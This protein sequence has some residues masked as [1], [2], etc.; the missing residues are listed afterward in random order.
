MIG[1]MAMG[2]HG[3]VRAT[4]DVDMLVRAEKGNIER[5]RIALRAAYPEDPFV[6][7][8]RD[9][10]LL[11][12]YAVVRYCPPSGEYYFD[13]IAKLGEMVTF[14]SVESEVKDVEGIR[15]RVA[16]PLALYRLKKGTIRPIDWQDAT[17]LRNQFQL[18]EDN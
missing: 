16:T 2:M 8:I 3:V 17:A 6:E 10:D 11:G 13:F 18:E 1:A 14:E 7:E 4:Q 15:I 5:I 9:D 12:D